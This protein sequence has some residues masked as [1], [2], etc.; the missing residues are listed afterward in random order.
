MTTIQDVPSPI[1]N[2][3]LL[4]GAGEIG[5]F[6]KCSE[7]RAWYMLEKKNIPAFKIGKKWHAR[8]ST[9]LRFIEEQEQHTL[10]AGAKSSVRE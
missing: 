4:V 2:D 1:S 9:L 5:A 6:L 8:R 10:S 3:D 7:R